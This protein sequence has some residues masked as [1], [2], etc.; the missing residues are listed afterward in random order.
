MFVTVKMRRTDNF[1][2]C[3][4]YNSLF[5]IHNLFFPLLLLFGVSACLLYIVTPLSYLMAFK[6]VRDC[7]AI[8]RHDGTAATIL[9]SKHA[10]LRTYIA[11][12]KP[13]RAACLW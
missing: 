7:A 1:Y 3:W 12:F 13:G 6:K 10:Y 9:V 5:Y 2:V 4:H 8:H 11:V